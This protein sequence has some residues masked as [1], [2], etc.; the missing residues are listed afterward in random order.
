[1]SLVFHV[2]VEL[3]EIQTASTLCTVHCISKQSLAPV[4]R[5]IMDSL[6]I[7]KN[8]R[9]YDLFYILWTRGVESKSRMNPS[10]LQLLV[11]TYYMTF[12]SNNQSQNHKGCD[13]M[14]SLQV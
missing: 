11:R 9:S 12:Y 4:S 3:G 1:M 6:V 2:Y 8:S 14:P 10:R 5:C 7:S 13:V